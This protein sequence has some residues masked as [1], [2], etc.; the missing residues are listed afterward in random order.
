MVLSACAE[1]K[2]CAHAIIV[3]RLKKVHLDMRQENKEKS[4]FSHFA[5]Y[6][7]T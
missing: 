5:G 4:F 1:F 3:V 2:A 7:N 6:A